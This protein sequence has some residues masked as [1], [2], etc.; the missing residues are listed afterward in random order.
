VVALFL[1]SARIL[2]R[3]GRFLFHHHGERLVLGDARE[4]AGRLAAISMGAVYMGAITYIG[5]AP[6]FMINAI[7][8]ERGIK[9]PS[10]FGYLLWAAVMLLPVFGV[11]TFVCWRAGPAAR[12]K[13]NA[14]PSLQIIRSEHEIVHSD[15]STDHSVCFRRIL[16]RVSNVPLAQHQIEHGRIG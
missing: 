9:M 5:N 6:N 12:S 4:L 16:V 3:G 11:L 14:A 2:A 13:S 1:I 10:F 8:V 7:A 15:R